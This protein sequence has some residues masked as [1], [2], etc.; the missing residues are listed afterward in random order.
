MNKNDEEIDI[1]S[2]YNE[3]WI[4]EM[5]QCKNCVEKKEKFEEFITFTEEI[6]L[7]S[8]NKSIQK[9]F[10]N[11]LRM[12]IP[13]ANSMICTKAVKIG[14][15]LLKTLKKNFEKEDAKIIFALIIDRFRENGIKLIKE[16]TNSLRNV[17]YC[18]DFHEVSFIFLIFVNLNLVTFIY[19]KF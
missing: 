14:G 19:I 4:E 8:P 18:L 1:F 2:K 16:C 10:I 11:L 13:D 9:S 5:I 15:I 12:N 3:N 6:S 7:I 17:F